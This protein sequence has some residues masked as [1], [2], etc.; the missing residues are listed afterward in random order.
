MVICF[1]GHFVVWFKLTRVVVFSSHGLKKCRKL[2]VYIQYNKF[3]GCVDHIVYEC[4]CIQ[5]LIYGLS[6]MSTIH[7]QIDGKGKDII[8]L[9]CFDP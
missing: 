5:L 9:R 7:L 3:V 2:K 6:S 1:G 4:C 8:C